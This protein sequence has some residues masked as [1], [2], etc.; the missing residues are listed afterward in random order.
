LSDVL[1]HREPP[2]GWRLADAPA[3]LGRAVPPSY[4]AQDRRRVPAD[5]I[6]RLSETLETTEGV[7]LCPRT[8]G[9]GNTPAAARRAVLYFSVSR[10][11]PSCHGAAPVCSIFALGSDGAPPR[12]G[13]LRVI[14]LVSAR[15][16]LAGGAW[17]GLDRQKGVICPAE[18]ARRNRR[19]ADYPREVLR[20]LLHRGRA[21]DQLF[22]PRHPDLPRGPG[23]RALSPPGSSAWLSKRVRRGGRGSGTRCG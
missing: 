5:A 8:V 16:H 9:S 14:Y 15:V 11:R 18:T 6:S 17:S 19:P 1:A 22:R 20:L 23:G 4:G 13:L 3:E 10:T 2:G 7:S 12:R 21:P